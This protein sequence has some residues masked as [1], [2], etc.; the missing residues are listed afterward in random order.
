MIFQELNKVK[1]WF[2]FSAEI[3]A[4]LGVKE[5]Y[6]NCSQLLTFIFSQCFV[7]NKLY[8]LIIGTY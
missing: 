4:N 6:F 1:Q 2:Q 7:G 8:L 5:P 3:L